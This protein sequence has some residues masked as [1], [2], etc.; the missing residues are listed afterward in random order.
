RVLAALRAAF[1]I[2]A[3]AEVTLEA[4]ANQ[5]LGDRLDAYHQQGFNRISFGVQTLDPSVRRTIG[6]GET[7]EDYERLVELLASRPWLPFNVDLMVGLPG[8][9]VEIFTDDVRRVSAWGIGSVD[10][11]TYWMVPG[12]RIYDGV[13]SQQGESPT[14]GAR[15][16][17]FRV[18]AK[19]IM[20]EMGF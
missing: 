17:E 18:A 3:D 12:S 2:A 9:T 11:Y 19:R 8:Q 5:L 15:L 13:V 20:K 6:R 16:L 1:P 14:Y 10:V 4:V 7:V